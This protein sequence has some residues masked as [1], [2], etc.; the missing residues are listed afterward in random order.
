MANRSRK[1][2]STFTWSDESPSPWPLIRIAVRSG[3]RFVKTSDLDGSFCFSLNLNLFGE[4]SLYLP[5]I[6]VL[7]TEN[8]KPPHELKQ[9]EM[10]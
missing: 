7:V 6:L 2:G 3:C 4:K 5:G 9:H 1:M 10:M 8:F